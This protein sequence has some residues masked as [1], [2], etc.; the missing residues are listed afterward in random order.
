MLPEARLGQARGS[1]GRVVPAP[2]GDEARPA[3]HDDATA[4]FPPAPSSLTTSTRTEVADMPL[5]TAHALT[6]VA[7]AQGRDLGESWILCAVLLAIALVCVAWSIP[8]SGMSA[9]FALLCLV[10]IGLE[11]ARARARFRRSVVR[12][13]LTRGLSEQEAEAAA[14]ALVK[15]WDTSRPGS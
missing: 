4:G 7:N 10:L 6:E 11:H 13:G 1:S 15:A 3:A 14:R 2:G 12:A 8:T 9:V 5:L